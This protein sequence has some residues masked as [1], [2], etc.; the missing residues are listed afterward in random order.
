M[1]P[2]PVRLQLS[3]KKGF[4]LQVLSLAINGLPAVKCSRPG[5]FGNPFTVQQAIDV[6][7]CNREAG[8]AYAVEWFKTWLDADDE[9]FEP[10]HCYEGTKERRDAIIRRLSELRGKNLAC[11]C[12]PD[13]ACHC[14]VLIE[15][16][17]ARTSEAKT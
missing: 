16:A 11:F 13:L 14:D 10:Y 2:H 12:G 6:F 5:P 17:R 8:H 15:R 7:Q 4:N 1:T 9:A 3:R